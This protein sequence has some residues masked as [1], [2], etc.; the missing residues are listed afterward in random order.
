MKLSLMLLSPVSPVFMN[1]DFTPKSEADLAEYEALLKLAADAGYTAVDLSTMEFE[2]FGVETVKTLLDKYGLI[3]GSVICFD[4]YTASDPAVLPRTKATIDATVAV[5]CKTLM[6]VAGF[7]DASSPREVMRENL[8][9]NLREAVRYAADKGVTICIEDFPSIVVPMCSAA[10]VDALLDGVPGLR[11]VYDSANM[12]V[13]GEEPL[14][15]HDHFADRIGYYHLKDVIITDDPTGDAMQNGKYLLA[16]QTGAG[17]MDFPA[18]LSKAKANGYSGY[19]SV[20]YSPR[21]EEWQHHLEIVTAA[22][23]LLEQAM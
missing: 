12:L 7:P 20:E 11:L 10:D 18:I 22:R 23:E 3:C 5:G 13:M 16:V 19:L 14:R 4:Y 9:A 8:I 17:L 21:G 6:L 2:H 15:Y 1:P